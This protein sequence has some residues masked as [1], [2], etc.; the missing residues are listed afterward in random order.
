MSIQNAKD[1]SFKEVLGNNQLFVEFLKDFIPID[2]LK[3]VSPEDIEDVDVR[4]IP[5]FNQNRDSDTVKRPWTAETNFLNRTALSEVFEKYIPKFEYEVVSLRQYSPE[6]LARF[7]DVLSVILLIDH[8]GTMKGK[9]F[10][11]ALPPGYLEQIGLKI[12]KNLTKIMSDVVTTL[13]T[14]FGTEKSEI[15]EITD[16]IEKKEVVPMFEAVVKEALKMKK[17]GYKQAKA[18]DREQIRQG[19]EQIRQ[20]EEKN[21][22]FEEKNR[23]LEEEVRL[24]RERLAGMESAD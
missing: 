22:Q 6:D 3:D 12:P 18:E 1:N 4:H 20:F 17:E 2:I 11:K 15:E 13:L 24:L 21:R 5:L 14:Q 9:N 7:N 16:Y 8:I 10:L 23:R 19:Q